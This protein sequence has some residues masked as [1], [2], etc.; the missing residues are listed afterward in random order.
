MEDFYNLP[1]WIR[2]SAKPV[3]PDDFFT[4]FPDNL[5]S[6]I[7]GETDDLSALKSL[8]KP[9]VPQGFFDSFPDKIMARIA[10]ED[11]SLHEFPLLAQLKLAPKP[12]VPAGYFNSF[13]AHIS[14]PQKKSRIISMPIWYSLAGA[15]A[16]ILL[17][18]LI[19]NPSQ[20]VVADDQ[21][22]ASSKTEAH[23]DEFL[24]YLD[25]DE[26][27]DYIVEHDIALEGDHNSDEH[28]AIYEFAGDDVEEYY[29]D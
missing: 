8:S 20:P 14:S 15:A 11:Q 18:F 26:I 3:V 17:F 27:I 10:E 6:V 21:Q 28:A 25:D 29:F 12:N 7:D 2:K 5:M 24:T 1:N 9:Q 16:V 13:S 4:R 22:T 23:H 19:Y